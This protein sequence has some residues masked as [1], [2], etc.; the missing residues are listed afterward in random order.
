MR[1]QEV[2]SEPART[3]NVTRR[4]GRASSERGMAGAPM[5]AKRKRGAAAAGKAKRAR[6]APSAGA[7]VAERGPQEHG[8]IPP[9]EY[10]IPPPVS[11]VP[12]LGLLSERV[13]LRFIR[14]PLP[15]RVKVDVAVRCFRGKTRKALVD[16]DVCYLS[17]RNI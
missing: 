14:N 1:A 8:I 6:S 10:S 11:Q 5:A 9:Q 12:P 16:V 7:A 2:S 4:A 15:A 17:L 13:L 3:G